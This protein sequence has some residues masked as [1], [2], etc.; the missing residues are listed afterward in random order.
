MLRQDATLGLVPRAAVG[1]SRQ[2]ECSMAADSGGCL[3]AACQVSEGVVSCLST[4]LCVGSM[5]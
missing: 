2:R 4:V 1:G 5:S 3:P